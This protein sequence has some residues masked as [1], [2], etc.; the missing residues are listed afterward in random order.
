MSIIMM[1]VMATLAL[2]VGGVIDYASLGNEKREIQAAAD[3]AAL[4]AARE[5]VITRPTQDRVQS[6]AEAY[7]A[8]NFHGENVAVTASISGRS[9]S[10]AVS[11]DPKTYFP[12]PI[13]LNART[14]SA[15]A[16]AEISG[17]GNVCMIGLSATANSTLNMSNTARLTASNCAIYS[18][19]RS[20][21]SLRVAN[22][23]RV[24]ANL[25]CVSGGVAGAA[26]AVN[27]PAI[28]DCPPISDPLRDH[29]DPNLGLLECDYL[30]T[31][32]ALGTVHLH[33]GVYCGGITVAL[34]GRAILE[35]GIY[36]MNNGLL[37]VTLNGKLEGQNVGFYLTGALSTIL[38]TAN[39]TVDLTAPKTGPLAG[40][41][42]FEDR[43]TIFATYHLI[44]SNNARNLVG[45]MYFPNSKL[46]IN[47]N[48]PVADRSDYTVIIAREFELSD[49]P[50][51]VL[52]TDYA[53]STI[54]LPDGVGDKARPEIRLTE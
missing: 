37:A 35:P 49:G 30:A 17:G 52:R 28:T 13:G 12:G 2:I 32:V 1:G 10:V 53:H 7:V 11:A 27:A 54:P 39:T 15:D 41:L 31:I 45:T 21:A 5:M 48:N 20:T 24:N 18:N 50:E 26:S 51:L 33:P 14:V 43:D 9:V 4:A 36:V 16:T 3:G 25:T 42:F 38:F 29:P 34:G 44:S 6:I 8:A 19:S 40:I 22:N 46:K 47:A 23:A